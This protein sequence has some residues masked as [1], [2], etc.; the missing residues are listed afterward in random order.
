MYFFVLCFIF[1]TLFLTF[2]SKYEK[3]IMNHLCWRDNY[4]FRF[5]SITKITFVNFINEKENSYIQKT[6]GQL[7]IRFGYSHSM[8][9]DPG[10]SSIHEKNYWIECNENVFVYISYCAIWN[11]ELKKHIEKSLISSHVDKEIR[12][13]WFCPILSSEPCLRVYYNPGIFKKFILFITGIL[14][15]MNLKFDSCQNVK[16]KENKEL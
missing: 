10:N 12:I 13:E 6:K 11:K 4:T 14:R 5:D 8:L 9:H 3:S 7:C 2:E 1:A 16:I 15:F